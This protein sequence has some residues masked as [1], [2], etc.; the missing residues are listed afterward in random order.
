MMIVVV[1]T[2]ELRLIK[3]ASKVLM[4]SDI[5]SS[6]C[7]PILQ[8]FADNRRG[9]ILSKLQKWQ[10][11]ACLQKKKKNT[12]TH[13]PGSIDNGVDQVQCTVNLITPFPFFPSLLPFFSTFTHA[14]THISAHALLHGGALLGCLCP[15]VWRAKGMF[16]HVCV[17]VCTC[18]CVCVCVCVCMC[19]CVCVCVC[20]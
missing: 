20:V 13:F 7:I 16:V 2:D 15:E 6:L 4:F 11:C 8:I 9:K 18:V 3:L 14:H 19:V 5:H 12:H 1:V 10:H 17:C